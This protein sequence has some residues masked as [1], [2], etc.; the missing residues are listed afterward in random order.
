MPSAGTG[1]ARA[2]PEDERRPGGMAGWPICAVRETFGGNGRFTPHMKFS[3]KTALK[4]LAVALGAVFLTLPAATAGESA[5]GGERRERL[6][7][8]ADHMADELGLSDTQRASI[9]ELAQRERAELDALRDNAALTKE[10]R[11]TKAH[12]I[13]E[14]YRSQRQAVLTPEQRVKADKMRGKLEKHRDRM[15]RREERQA[16]FRD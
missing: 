15:E 1:E 14:K 16:K 10:E 6:Q 7:Q 9:K 4:S 12:E 13:R 2:P 8:G 11:K 3:P 5:P